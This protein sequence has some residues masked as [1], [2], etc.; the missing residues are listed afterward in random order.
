M[1]KR[2][3]SVFAAALALCLLL[4]ACGKS[5][6]VSEDVSESVSE[7]P[8]ESEEESSQTESSSVQE[9]DER[10][11]FLAE[12]KSL[13]ERDS[14]YTELLITAGVLARDNAPEDKYASHTVSPQNRYYLSQPL[15]D[16]LA[17]VYTPEGMEEFASYPDYGVKFADLTGEIAK[18][19]HHFDPAPPVTP[20]YE[21][22]YIKEFGEK[23]A[24]LAVPDISGEEHEVSFTLTDEGWRLDRAYFFACRGSGYHPLFTT[25][26]VGSAS[27]I[28]GRCL[29]INVFISDGESEWN[30]KDVEETLG[31]VRAAAEFISRFAAEYGGDAEFIVSSAAA[32]PRLSTAEKLPDSPEGFVRIDLL[33]GTTV[34]GSLQNYIQEYYDLGVYDNYCVLLHLNKPGRSYALECDTD[35]FDWESYSCERAVFYRSEDKKYEY[36]CSEAT[37]AHELLHLFGAADLYGENVAQEVSDLLA[38]YY[39]NDIMSA[40]GNDIELYGISPFTAYLTG[41]TDALHEQFASLS[42]N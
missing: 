36:Y 18:Y 19:S 33:F 20:V 2:Y 34:F 22:A 42:D 10:E 31:K 30:D 26:T 1:K 37:Y 29:L 8:A 41:I 38:H 17:A 25:M 16:E 39:P 15:A 21:S 24:I 7:L 4:C 28:R 9:P 12:A 11:L 3:L 6:A 23:T 5:E 14:Y 32:S 35:D 27:A 40:V 13:L